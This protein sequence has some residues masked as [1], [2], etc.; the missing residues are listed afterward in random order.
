MN[1]HVAH[2]YKVHGVYVRGDPSLTLSVLTA[3]SIITSIPAS[4]YTFNIAVM[5]SSAVSTLFKNSGERYRPI[6]VYIII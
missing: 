6:E 5:I 4:L 2:I 3:V 1:V